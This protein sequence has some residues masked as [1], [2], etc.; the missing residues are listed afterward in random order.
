M[1]RSTERSYSRLDALTALA[2]HAEKKIAGYGCNLRRQQNLHVQLNR[3]DKR[4][5]TSNKEE[6]LL[7]WRQ[8]MV[9]GGGRLGGR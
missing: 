7:L 6:L 9:Q 4:M 8:E 1:D 3:P 2:G 5:T